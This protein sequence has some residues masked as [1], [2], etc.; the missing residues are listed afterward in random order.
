VRTEEES[1][2]PPEERFDALFRAARVLLREGIDQEDQVIPTL[3]L[4]N[5]TH[6]EGPY[7]DLRQRFKKLVKAGEGWERWVDEWV[8]AYGSLRP[9]RMV[10]EVLIL[11]RLPISIDI[12]YGLHN[13]EQPEQVFLSVYPHRQPAESSHVAS[14]YEAKLSA[15]SAPYGEADTGRMSF[16][17]FDSHLLITIDRGL[18]KFV[19]DSEGSSFRFRTDVAS[20]PTPRIVQGF[21]QMLLGKPS[22]EG[23]YGHLAT[24]TRG[25]APN[26]DNL[27]LA[28]VA[29]Y[30]RNSGGIKGRKE[31]HR[32]LNEHVLCE[33]RYRHKAI[34][35][36]GC[37]SSVASQIWRDAKDDTKVCKPLKDAEL[38]L[39]LP[40]DV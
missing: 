28:C 23:F 36:E 3:T 20:F 5:L 22:G 18:R 16:E 4:A 38:T 8:S 7:L 15:A 26:A 19:S 31:I 39:L 32:L 1:L 17:L 29:F 34:P 24:R 12:K 35:E 33:E 10:G 2:P 40:Y 13:V 9:V 37:A 25:G 30:L 27:I 14:L 21:Y 6:E 11:E